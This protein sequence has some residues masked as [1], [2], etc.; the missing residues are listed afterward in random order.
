[1]SLKLV[2]ERGLVIAKFVAENEQVRAAIEANM[3]TLKESLEK[4]GFS[5]QEFSVSVNHNKNRQQDGYGENPKNLRESNTEDKGILTGNVV[6][7]D[8]EME[9]AKTN[10]YILNGSS[11]N[12]TA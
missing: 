5:V 6:N 4:Q 7:T 1:L 3:D 10:P 12:L 9:I 11:I 8:I 2:T